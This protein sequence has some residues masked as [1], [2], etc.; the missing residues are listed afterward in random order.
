VLGLRSGDNA[1]AGVAIV[2]LDPCLDG[3]SS[4]SI[5]DNEVDLHVDVNKH[6]HEPDH[7]HGFSTAVDESVVHR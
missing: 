3:V 2:S 7:A 6:N 4:D 5:D 1:D